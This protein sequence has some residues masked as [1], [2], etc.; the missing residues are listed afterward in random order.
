MRSSRGTVLLL[1]PPLVSIA[2]RD[3]RD[4]TKQPCQRNPRRAP[5]RP[6]LT[7]DTGFARQLCISASDGTTRMLIRGPQPETVRHYRLL[8]DGVVV[9]EESNNFLRKRIHR[10]PTPVSGQIVV[11]ECLATHGAPHARIFEVRLYA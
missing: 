6:A 3:G 1:L 7:F 4:S 9:V 5:Q 8:I 11:L 2:S 10:L